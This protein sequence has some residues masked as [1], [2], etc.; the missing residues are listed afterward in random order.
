MTA[1]GPHGSE[2]AAN[3]GNQPPQSHGGYVPPPYL[4]KF[5]LGILSAVLLGNALSVTVLFPFLG[6]L[7]EHLGMTSDRRKLGSSAPF[8][9]FPCGTP[10]Y[11]LTQNNADEMWQVDH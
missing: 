4:P 2:G 9:A 11:L 5:Y 6:L 3:D 7:V 8:S 10:A 1:R